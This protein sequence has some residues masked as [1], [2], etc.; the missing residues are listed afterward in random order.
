MAYYFSKILDCSF[1]EAESKLREELKKEGF[2]VL[3]DID[4]QATLKTKIGEDFRKYKIL[5][6]CNPK[7][8]HKA[9]LAESQIGTMLPC[10]IVIQENPE[11]KIEVSVVDP[12]KSM[13]AIEN[14]K[15]GEVATEAQEKLKKVIENL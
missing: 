6:A 9:L 12:I 13:Q 1:E 4:V 2:G 11:N 14:P 3:T 10:N 15:L 8:A 7:L 5:G